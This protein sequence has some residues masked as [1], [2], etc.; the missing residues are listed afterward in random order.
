M[1]QRQRPEC[2]K[3]AFSER[4]ESVSLRHPRSEATWE[5]GS[6][7]SG[8]PGFA[9]TEEVTGSNPVAPTTPALTRAFIG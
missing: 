3:R 2:R 6:Q 5:N 4:Q 9:D 8:S 1:R 7:H